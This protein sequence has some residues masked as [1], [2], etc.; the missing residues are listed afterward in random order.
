MND[1]STFE[2][3]DLY[4]KWVQ[5]GHQIEI[6]EHVKELGKRWLMCYNF[7]LQYPTEKQALKVYIHT[8]NLNDDTARR[9]FAIAQYV[10]GKVKMPNRNFLLQ[11]Q[12]ARADK[13]YEE[14]MEDQ[15]IDKALMAKAIDIKNR[16][17]AMLPDETEPPNMDL[18]QFK[19]SYSRDPEILGEGKKM[20]MAEL[21][22]VFEKIK[23]KVIPRFN[24]DGIAE[25]TPAVQP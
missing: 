8:M 24:F 2:K 20:E 18:F 4:L 23:A 16:I 25:D 14:V 21:K 6:S 9:D 19:I 5:T 11:Q 13:L 7:M 22:Q 10:F 15:V 1:I 12:L 17:I 3:A